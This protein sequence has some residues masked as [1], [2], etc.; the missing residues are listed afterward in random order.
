MVGREFAH[1]HPDPDHS[2]HMM[3][4]MPVVELAIAS[5]WG[6]PHPVA[7][8][9]LIPPTAMM[10]YAPRDQDELTVPTP[11]RR[12]NSAQGRQGIA[13]Y[14]CPR[15]PNSIPAI[16]RSIVPTGGLP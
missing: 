10:I 6:E 16:C 1:V 9:G 14:A 4:P 2:L 13:V 11:H 12:A 3:L 7:R 15:R 8:R 5:G